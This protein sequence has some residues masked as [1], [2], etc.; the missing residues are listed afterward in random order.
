ML[1]VLLWD[2][3][4]LPRPGEKTAHIGKW[5]TGVSAALVMV[6]KGGRAVGTTLFV[7]PR[8]RTFSNQAMFL[9]D[10]PRLFPRA[11][12]AAIPHRRPHGRLHVGRRRCR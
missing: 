2:Y 4:E 12:A 11:T 9:R 5:V 6:T 10:L 7:Q 3:L 1:L 8:A